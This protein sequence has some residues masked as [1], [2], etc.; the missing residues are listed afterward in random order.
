MTDFTPPLVPV[1]WNP[2][3]RIIPSRFPPIDLFA[4]VAD[5]SDLD[6][7]FA[8]ESLTS[9]QARQEAGELRLVSPEDAVSG[10]GSQWIMGP[11]AHVSTPGGRFSTEEFGAYYAAKSLATA[12]EETKYHRARFLRATAEPPMVIDMRVLHARLAALV[13]D[14][15]GLRAD[16][17]ELYHLTDY[18]ASQ[19]F[20][21]Q[22]RAAR[23]W[24]IVFESVR[25][26][27]GECVAVFRPSVLS[28]CKQAQHL[29]YV[30][31]GSK[32]TSVF[33]KRLVDSGH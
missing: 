17:P 29:A 28:D 11:F 12:I 32:I 19:A 2:C 8:I 20:A 30:W 18:S 7:V 31:D 26:D 14:L 4:R 21:R 1:R 5:P 3:Y 15:R 6:A 13:H 27:G 22:L 23:S 10:P 9:T 25:H 24:G 16:H 33:E